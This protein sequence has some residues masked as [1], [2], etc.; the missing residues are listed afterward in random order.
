MMK[1]TELKGSFFFTL[2]LFTSVNKIKM[3][4]KGIVYVRIANH[5][6]TNENVDGYVLYHAMP[7]TEKTKTQNKPTRINERAFSTPSKLP[8]N[9]T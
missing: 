2:L 4:K 3:Q 1:I 6:P 8:H 5:R 9:D 7:M